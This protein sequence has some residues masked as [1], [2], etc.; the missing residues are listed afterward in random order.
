MCANT[1]YNGSHNGVW[2]P[3][4]SQVIGHVELPI[5]K[6]NILLMKEFPLVPIKEN[7]H[8]S[9]HFNF[10]TYVLTP[11]IPSRAYP[12]YNAIPNTS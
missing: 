6:M 4:N 2:S 11:C 10:R 12:N 8:I 7:C 3:A 5:G 9:T 1:T